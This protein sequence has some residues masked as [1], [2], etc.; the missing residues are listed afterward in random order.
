[1]D[2]N[3]FKNHIGVFQIPAFTLL[4][5]GFLNTLPQNEIRS[6]FA[7]VVKHTL[8]ADRTMWDIIRTKPLGQQDWSVLMKHSVDIK[9]KVVREDPKENGLRKIL[10]AGHTIGHAVESYLLESNRKIM[11]G[12]AVAAGLIAE[13]FIAHQRDLLTKQSLD[14]ISRYILSVFGKVTIDEKELDAIAVLTLQDKKNKGNRVLCVLLEG[15]GKAMWDFEISIDEIKG[16]L[17]FYRTL[18]M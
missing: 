14:E 7:E 5:S 9:S 11:H 12:E 2:F 18:Q 3:S 6:G 16:A 15:I 1:V 17:S 13:A 4:H 10:N 8:I